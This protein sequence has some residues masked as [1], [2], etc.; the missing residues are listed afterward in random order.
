MKRSRT[1][2]PTTLLKALIC[3]LSLAQNDRASNAQENTS[4]LMR[5]DLLTVVLD[6]PVSNPSQ[7]ANCM[8]RPLILYDLTQ[9]INKYRH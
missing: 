9:I 4:N 3:R 2:F 1:N 7:M 5:Y 6:P 8:G